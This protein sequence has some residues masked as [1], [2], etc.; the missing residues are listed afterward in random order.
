MSF[1]VFKNNSETDCSS[2]T[3]KIAPSRGNTVYGSHKAIYQDIS[4]VKFLSKANF[5]VHLVRSNVTKR[6]Y[7][8]K[9]FPHKD[10]QPL[11]HYVNETRF[12]CL[13]HPNVVRSLYFENQRQVKFDGITKDVSYMIMEYAQ[14]GDFVNFMRLHHAKIDDILARTYFRHLIQGLEYLHNN[15][16]GHLDIKLDNLLLSADYTL[17][18]GD[19]DT[20]HFSED[21]IILS[22][23]TKYYR[24]PEIIKGNCSDPKPADFYSAGVVLFLL[25]TKGIFPQLEDDTY[26][27]SDLGDLLQT[28]IPQFWNVH[29]RLQ[30]KERSFFDKDFCDLFIGMT[31]KEPRKRLTIDKIKQS[32]WYNGPIYDNEELKKI[33][34]KN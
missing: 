32:N 21:A 11:I 3:S 28:N 4:I 30:R 1:I 19:F 14:N 17:K 6:T 24:A 27:N 13:Q 33:F 20:A 9:V 29:R 31:R 22:Q 10:G 5:S 23:G 8:M 16:V 15:E 12:A 34:E 25:K 26:E 2:S 18:I 7:A